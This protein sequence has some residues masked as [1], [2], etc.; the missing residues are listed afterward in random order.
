M[1]VWN[2]LI[3]FEDATLRPLRFSGLA[4]PHDARAVVFNAN[5]ERGVLRGEIFHDCVAPS[6]N[7]NWIEV[8]PPKEH[9]T[10]A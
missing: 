6:F 4:S 7:A 9:K 8:K 1:I 2:A 3:I 10:N 5:R